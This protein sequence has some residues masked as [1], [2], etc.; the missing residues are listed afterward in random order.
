MRSW[1]NL[2]TIKSIRITEET[3]KTIDAAIVVTNHA[4]V[5]YDLILRR[6]PLVIDTRGVY[7]NQNGKIHKA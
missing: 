3:L 5:D 7:R 1:P 2:P 4:Q 6:V